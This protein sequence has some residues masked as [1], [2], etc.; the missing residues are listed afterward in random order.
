MDPVWFDPT[1]IGFGLGSA[2]VLVIAALFSTRGNR[3]VAGFL[4]IM[5]LATKVW[6]YRTGTDAQLY[7]DTAL[8]CLCGLLCVAVMGRER[9]ALWPLGVL[10]VMVMWIVISAAYA[11]CRDYGPQVKWAYQLACNVLFGVALFVCA[12]SGGRRGCLVLLRR[13]SPR[14][15]VRPRLSLGDGWGRDASNAISK[16]RAKV[17]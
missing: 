15:S 3:Y 6:N 17:R 1:T 16:R 2:A 8:A 11:E 7:L 4:W 9:R 12:F 13:L 10:G 14:V 5:W